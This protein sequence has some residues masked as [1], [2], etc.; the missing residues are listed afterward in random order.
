MS[1]RLPTINQVALSGRLTHDPQ[2]RFTDA[3][4]ALLS[5]SIA[6]NHSF[7]NKAGEW[8]EETSFVSVVLWDKLAEWGSSRLSKGSSVFVSG[9]LKSRQSER[10]TILEVI[11]RNLQLL[12][13][14][15]EAV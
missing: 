13:K 7:R 4:V 15:E 2:F 3:G 10:K 11:V 14:K 9:R 6:L 12:D 5:C 8:E 1:I